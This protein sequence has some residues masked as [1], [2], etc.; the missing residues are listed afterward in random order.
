MST[1]KVHSAG[2]AHELLVTCPSDIL[3][4]TAFPAATVQL[5]L[6]AYLASVAWA[7]R[8]DRRDCSTLAEQLPSVEARWW[9]V[10][11][12]AVLAIRRAAGHGQPLEQ[13]VPFTVWALPATGRVT[14]PRISRLSMRE[15]LTATPRAALAAQLT[16]RAW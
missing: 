1:I 9:E 5:T 15:Q 14:R 16:V 4:A 2:I 8:G 3:V 13:P 10:L 6:D 7:S 12:A 11:H